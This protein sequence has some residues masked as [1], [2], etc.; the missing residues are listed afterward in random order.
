[1]TTSLLLAYGAALA[2]AVAIPGP[3]VVSVVSTGL[4]G[5]ARKGLAM[6]A[7]IAL[8]D[9]VLGA[10][11]LLGLAVINAS[12]DWLFSVMRYASAAYLVY[13][14]FRLGLSGLAVEARDSTGGGRLGEAAALGGAVALGNPKAILFHASLM[15]LIIN[16][17]VL[18]FTDGA[19]ILAAVLVVNLTVMSAYALLSGRMAHWLGK[20]K[21]LRL[22]NQSAGVA[23]IGTGT[24]IAIR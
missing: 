14:G 13:L 23:M 9:V 3:A 12:I 24:F 19:A 17:S 10:A 15:P 1:M 6:A 21:R 5:G 18:D 11:A 2:L 22:L 8:G 20:P 4:A 7:G 16:V